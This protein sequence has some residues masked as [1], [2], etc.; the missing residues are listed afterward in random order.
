MHVFTDSKVALRDAVSIEQAALFL[1]E[2][3]DLTGQDRT[4]MAELTRQRDKPKK[5][6][7]EIAYE[8]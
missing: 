7:Q 5:Q 3:L 4:L 6:Q 1:G 2:L 8:R